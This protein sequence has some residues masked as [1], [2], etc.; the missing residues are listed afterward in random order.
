MSLSFQ[1]NITISAP[2]CSKSEIWRNISILYTIIVIESSI[3]KIRERNQSYCDNIAKNVPIPFCFINYYNLQG[4]YLQVQIL[5][6]TNANYCRY[7]VQRSLRNSTIDLVL[8]MLKYL[9]I[10]Y[11]YSVCQLQ[12]SFLILQRI[13]RL[14][15]VL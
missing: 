9:F 12:L 7:T 15:S 1:Q 3:S 2:L 11:L 5:T 10:L 8:A 4:L 6:N 13:S 14:A